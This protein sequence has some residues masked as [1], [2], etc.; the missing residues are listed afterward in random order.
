MLSIVVCTSDI[1]NY[2]Y[3]FIFDYGIAT[4]Q[5]TIGLYAFPVPIFR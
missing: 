4:S 1:Q 2:T 3:M 5:E